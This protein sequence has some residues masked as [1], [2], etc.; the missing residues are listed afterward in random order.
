[1]NYYLN[2]LLIDIEILHNENGA[3]YV[4]SEKVMKKLLELGYNEIDVSI[5]HSD[6]TAISVCEI[7]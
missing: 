3:P 6:K 5:S 7:L 1:M 2:N 4:N